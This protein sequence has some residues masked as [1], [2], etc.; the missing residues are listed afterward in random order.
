MLSAGPSS[1]WLGIVL[2]AYDSGEIASPFGWF[3]LSDLRLAP[4]G[5]RTIQVRLLA[6]R[7]LG[8][9]GSEADA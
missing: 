3:E 7:M 9:P 4:A 6:S 2:E 5:T 8:E 1:T